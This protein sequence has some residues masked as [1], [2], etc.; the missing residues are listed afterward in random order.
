MKTSSAL[1]APA[2]TRCHSGYTLVELMV[3]LAIALFLL[4]GLF[5]IVQGTRTTYGN[6]SQ[7]AQLQDNERLTMTLITD[8]I[9]AAGYF[10][11]PQKHTAAT[12]LQADGTMFQ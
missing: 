5:T 2:G 7:L 9:H 12:S 11:Y 6:Q 3:A 1:P 4:G 10:P 8:M